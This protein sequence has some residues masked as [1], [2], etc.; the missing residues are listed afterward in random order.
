MSAIT[1]NAFPPLHAFNSSRGWFLALIVL[2]H[3]GF[4]W[5]LTHGLTVWTIEKE[6]APFIVDFV[7]PPIV[8]P[9]VRVPDEPRVTSRIFVPEVVEPRLRHDDDSKA[10]VQITKETQPPP[11]IVTEAPGSGPVI[12]PAI[13]ARFP[14]SEPEY[15]V[16]EIRMQ[17]AGTVWLSVQI[18]PNGRVGAV[19]LDQSSGYAR[20]DDSAMR[21]ARHWRMKP[22]TQDGVAAAMWKRV[23]ITFRLKD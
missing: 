20:L 22:G 15:P 8:D 5:G 9:P 17:H 21:E 10:P 11:V 1:V 14:L 3:L 19:R 23:P 7:P 13:D 2:V 18:L 4:F 12:E 16:P 6:V